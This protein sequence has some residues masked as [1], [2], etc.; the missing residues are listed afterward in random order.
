[1]CY[2]FGTFQSSRNITPKYGLTMKRWYYWAHRYLFQS[3]S[4]SIKTWPQGN[5]TPPPPFHP[6][7]SHSPLHCLRPPHCGKGTHLSRAFPVWGCCLLCGANGPAKENC[8]LQNVLSMRSGIADIHPFCGIRKYINSF[9][10]LGA[11]YIT[12]TYSKQCNGQLQRN[13]RYGLGLP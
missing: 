9:W 11:Q 13:T 4:L 3:F 8:Q 1:M 5:L 7:P 10:L 12:H 6:H 2:F